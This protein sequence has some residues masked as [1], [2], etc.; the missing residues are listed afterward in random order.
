VRHEQFR[1]FSHFIQ[2]QITKLPMNK[3]EITRRNFIQTLLTGVLLGPVV[4]KT[5]AFNASG[6]PTRAL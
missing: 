5:Q 6:I 1:V 3:H 4:L 2:Y